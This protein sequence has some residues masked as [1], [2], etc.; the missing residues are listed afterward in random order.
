MISENDKSVAHMPSS[1]ALIDGAH[2]RVVLLD[3]AR[4]GA[5]IIIRTYRSLRLAQMVAC[6]RNLNFPLPLDCRSG[7]LV[8][9]DVG[10]HHI[11]TDHRGYVCPVVEDQDQD[12]DSPDDPQGAGTTDTAPGLASDLDGLLAEGRRRSAALVAAEERGRADEQAMYES[13]RIERWRLLREEV[14]RELPPALLA[15]TGLHLGMPPDNFYTGMTYTVAIRL[16]APDGMV[17][18]PVLRC[19]R[20]SSRLSGECHWASQDTGWCVYNSDYSYE[21][22]DVLLVLARAETMAAPK[23]ADVPY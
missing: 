22:K 15:Y 5:G 6:D 18:P 7:N 23:T 17:I 16:P 2:Y 1:R 9:S 8:M 4:P 20:F 19:Y 3:P 21:S 12:E 11:V 10:W 14:A 13:R